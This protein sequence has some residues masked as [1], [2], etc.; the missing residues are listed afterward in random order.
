MLFVLVVVL[1]R[2]P[3]NASREV[4]VLGKP[5]VLQLTWMMGHAPDIARN[6]AISVDDPHTDNL[7]KAGMN[8]RVHMAEHIKEH[9][10]KPVPPLQAV[11]LDRIQSLSENAS[12]DTISPS[13]G[14]EKLGDAV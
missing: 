2:Q 3:H 11:T 9:V 7:L 10:G 1:T 8:I 5:G 13:E 6:L 14:P 4:D 12:T